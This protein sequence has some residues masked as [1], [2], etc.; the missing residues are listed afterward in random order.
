MGIPL[1]P[2][3][4]LGALNAPP[5]APISILFNAGQFVATQINGPKRV[6]LDTLEVA[7]T[8]SESIDYDSDVTEFEV[9][10]GAKVSDHRRTSPPV[11]TI[12]G[13]VSDTPLP[14]NLVAQ[15][16]A[17]AA[18]Q[19][20]LA[21]SA[22]QTAVGLT[23]DALFTRAAFEKLERLFEK[24]AETSDGSEATFRI[25]TKFRTFENMVVKSLKFSR[26]G[27]TGLALPFQAVFR[28]LRFVS[29]E[30]GTFQTVAGLQGP[31]PQGSQGGDKAPAKVADD[32]K[33]ISRSWVDRNLNGAGDRAE[34]F[35]DEKL[36]SLELS[37]L[38]VASNGG[39]LTGREL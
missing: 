26:D 12:S 14:S 3:G 33:T 7:C 38:G 22:A 24:G 30:V 17:A 27:G 21:L 32:G 15:A 29:T 25:V 6:V 16:V 4:A 20:G 19:L 18:P 9:E 10:E 23:N 34:R 37:N 36:K 28:Q 35:L 11:Y 39:A 31:N 8:L 13:V 1:D 5:L 2:T